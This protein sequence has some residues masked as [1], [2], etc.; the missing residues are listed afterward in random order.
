MLVTFQQLRVLLERKRQSLRESLIDG[1]RLTGLNSAQLSSA[2]EVS[3]HGGA[4]LDSDC[5]GLVD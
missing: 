2:I 3:G 5:V 4:N 1:R